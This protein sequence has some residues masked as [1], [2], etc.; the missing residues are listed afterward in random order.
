MLQNALKGDGF[1]SIDLKPLTDNTSRKRSAALTERLE[2]VVAALG[3]PF[4]RGLEQASQ[5]DLDAYE[6]VVAR[7]QG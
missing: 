7:F 1:G 6:A 4:Y 5:A 2:K 3:Q